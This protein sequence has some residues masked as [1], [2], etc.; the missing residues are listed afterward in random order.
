MIYRTTKTLALILFGLS[1]F[2][3]AAAQKME[4]KTPDRFSVDADAL[5]EDLE[6]LSSDEMKGRRTGT[7]ESRK[8]ARY[9]AK[10]FEESGIT[11]FEGGYLDAFKFETKRKKKYEGENVI[12]LIKGRSKPESY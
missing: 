12:G 6:F 2:S 3:C 11:A 9:V 7:P 4:K 8:A 1:L 10:R 5:M